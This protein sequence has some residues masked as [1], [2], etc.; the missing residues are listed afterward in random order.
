MTS[1]DTRCLTCGHDAP[2]ISPAIDYGVP[3]SGD[4]CTEDSC[5]C[6]QFV[7]APS[8]DTRCATC[9]EG[10][11]A[12]CPTDG[13]LRHRVLPGSH[14][15]HTF[16][17]APS[18]ADAVEAAREVVVE[19]HERGVDYPIYLELS[20]FEAAIVARERERYEGTKEHDWATG[21]I[22]APRVP[23]ATAG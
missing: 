22:T 15:H 7:P 19:R 23:P 2:H 16:V 4:V 6:R 9:G 8:T 14:Y 18:T 10:Q 11:E 20:N 1:P 13:Y 3:V 5:E 17:L 12:R 21:A